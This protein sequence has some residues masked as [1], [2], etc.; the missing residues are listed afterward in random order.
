[1]DRM[2]NEFGDKLD[3]LESQ[4]VNDHGGVQIRPERREF[5]VMRIVIQVNTNADEFMADNT[6]MSDVDFE[7]VLMRH[8]EHFGQQQNFQFVGEKYGDNFGY[9]GNYMYRD[10]NVELGGDLDT[11]KLKASVF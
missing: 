3:R 11:I 2:T 7:D 4:H 6:N 8:G 1:M 10:H 9:K 5:N